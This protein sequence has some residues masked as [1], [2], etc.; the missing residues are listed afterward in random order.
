MKLINLAALALVF[1]ILYNLLFFHV[2]LGIGNGIFYL[3]LHIFFFIT[4]NQGGYATKN[5][6]NLDY[7][8]SS[9]AIAIIFAFLFS[10]IGN[11]FVQFIDVL[12]AILFSSIALFFY[13]YEPRFSLNLPNFLLIPL[14]SFFQTVSN[15]LNI[16][17]SKEKISGSKENELTPSF[18]RGG[19]I[20]LVLVGVL[21]WLLTKGDLV[22]GTIVNNFL[23]SIWERL[24]F[25][26]LVFISLM[27]FGLIKIRKHI[28]WLDNEVSP[29][30]GKVQE[31]AIII[32]SIIAL[33]TL[34]MTVQ[35]R[36]LFLPVGEMDLREIGISSATY[37]EYVRAGFTELLFAA[38]IVGGVLIYVS[39]YTHTLLAR[40]KGIIQILA[41]ILT[42][43]NGLILVSATKR[44]FL[45]MDAHGLTRAREFGFAFLIWL[46][47][48]L[49]ILLIGIIHRISRQAQTK[50]V[51]SVTLV[52]L[53]SINLINL[54]ELIAEKYPPTVNQEID[55]TYLTSLSTDAY[56]S[57]VPAIN[58]GE[59]ILMDLSS[60]QKIEAED[61]RKFIYVR[62]SLWNIQQQHLQYLQDKYGPKDLQAKDRVPVADLSRMRAWQAFNLSEYFAY[63]H[64][65]DNKEIFNK[66]PKL[67][68]QANQIDQKV[69]MEVRNST[70][71]DRSTNTP[72]TY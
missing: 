39:R 28:S 25:S 61:Y 40:Q 36:Y 64:I 24:I 27:N 42:L 34:F 23:S 71:F 43:E 6:K 19:V 58:E 3:L 11:G 51:L 56:K 5:T 67:L 66:V 32:G 69:S 20:A 1:V 18:I 35:F 17:E 54:D 53:I 30:L 14:S 8:I 70:Q 10:S 13:Q 65:R 12:L 57:W 38:G 46:S 21:L 26:A 68:E 55:Y 31:L 48:I 59:K 15:L 47:F 44:L 63:Q 62:N 33:F 45:Y 9:S 2:D 52:I 22:F 50:L 49:A 41:T 72:L 37:S 29:K 16:F 60:K 7:A 4:R